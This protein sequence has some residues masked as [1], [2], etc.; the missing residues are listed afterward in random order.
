MNC[1]KFGRHRSVGRC[2]HDNFF[3][4]RPIFSASIKEINHNRFRLKKTS[5]Q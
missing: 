3:N 2:S 4:S 1:G 5:S